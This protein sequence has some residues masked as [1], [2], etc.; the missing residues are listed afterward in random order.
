[1]DPAN[2]R[3]TRH[4][5]EFGP[6]R[7]NLVERLLVRDGERISLSPKAFET[8]RILVQHSGH[9]LTK[10]E[11]MK[12]LWPH[13]FVEENNLTQ[14]ISQLRRALG[15]E[16]NG[17]LYI[18]TVPK[19]GYRFIPAVRE[20]LDD[21]SATPFEIG[22]E[23][24]VSKRTRTR[25]LLHEE[26]ER[27]ET[28]ETLSEQT[29]SVA[30]GSVAVPEKRTKR[31]L[32]QWMGFPVATA[33]VLLSAY[34]LTVRSRTPHP[35]NPV[36]TLAVIPFRDLKPGSETQFLSYSLA[37]AIVHR[38]GYFNELVV[39]PSSY[40]AK[41]RG[42]EAEPRAVAQELHTEAVL[43]GNYLRDGNRLRVSA[44]LVD[45]EKA[46]VLWHDRWEVP[47][48][49]LFTVQ[50]RVAENVARGMRL[51][52][53]APTVS[54]LQQTAPKNALAYEYFLRGRDLGGPN[55]YRLSIEMLKKSIELDPEYA[56]TWMELGVAYQ[57]HADWEGGGE[58]SAANSQAAFEKALELDPQ[59]PGLHALMA[60]R[61]IEHGDLDESVST[62]RDAIR[63]NPNDAVAHWWL[64]EAYLYGGML[65]ESIAE[66]EKAL[67]LDPMV[68]SGSTLNSY[69]HNGDYHKFLAS[70]P[71]DEG[72]RTVFY[73]GLC[74]LYMHDE[75]RAASEFEEAYALDPDLLH[76]KYGR[77]FLYAIRNQT[78]EA[79]KYLLELENSSAT[80]DGEMLFKIAQAYTR[81]GDSPSAV[82]LLQQAVSHNFYCYSCFQHDPLTS[83]LRGDSQYDELLRLARVRSD[84]FK[85]RYF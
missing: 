10:D 19:L 4:L 57:G 47:Y 8:L 43:T 11:L 14:Q 30:M 53:L 41:Y 2:A 16:A 5:Y 79:R 26:E 32:A 69:L 63:L 61:M 39:R 31:R 76:A 64:T 20:I 78:A 85:R 59:L 34:F 23:M 83:S 48:D 38:L 37:D 71:H 56:P 60:I 7:L 49:Q 81:V 22:S 29:L 42:G 52:I 28:D 75:T 80:T 51:Q 68:N 66:G 35:A 77:A 74:Y 55:Q 58:A 15:E 67:A 6:F 33:A 17:L 54:H 25:I 44:E 73:R 1:M 82:R 24:F 36:R 3:E 62:L 21:D 50:D 9:V 13:S 46:E 27:E 40:V 72:A 18:E 65:D 45:V 12:T 84:N 70:L